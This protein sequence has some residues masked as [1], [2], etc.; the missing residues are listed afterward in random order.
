LESRG[1]KFVSSPSHTPR[2]GGLSTW[3]SDS[4]TRGSTVCIFIVIILL[5]QSVRRPLRFKCRLNV[6]LNVGLNVSSIGVV[7]IFQATY[8]GSNYPPG[9]TPG[10]RLYRLSLILVLLSYGYQT[11][12]N[13]VRNYYRTLIGTHTGKYGRISIQ[14]KPDKGRKNE[15]D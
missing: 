9:L 12:A 2:L 5:S 14:I 11:A 15:A 13:F 3:L 4:L 8:P 7:S 6:G 10:R 1:E